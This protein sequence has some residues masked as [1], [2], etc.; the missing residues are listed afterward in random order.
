MLTPVAAM[1]LRKG[2]DNAKLLRP[3]DEEAEDGLVNRSADE[4]S[5][6]TSFL[7]ED[8]LFR[9]G[10]RSKQFDQRPNPS[11]QE[12][13]D[14]EQE[15]MVSGVRYEAG[16]SS[17]PKRIGFQGCYGGLNEGHGF[18]PTAPSAIAGPEGYIQV[19]M[20]ALGAYLNTPGPY[21]SVET[22]YFLSQGNFFI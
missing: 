17:S 3:N 19:A 5:C 21:K 22:P 16:R 7:I 2:F 8:I 20:G 4:P 15:A 18:R 9:S 1:E 6:K 11:R 10:G 13:R 12:R 14:L